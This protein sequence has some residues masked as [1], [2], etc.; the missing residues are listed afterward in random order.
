MTHDEE[1][2]IVDL[3]DLLSDT[4]FA[5]PVAD[6]EYDSFAIENAGSRQSLALNLVQPPP[7]EI[8][9]VRAPFDSFSAGPE[10]IGADQTT[11]SVVLRL[12]IKPQFALLSFIEYIRLSPVD[13]AAPDGRISAGTV[14]GTATDVELR[15]DFFCRIDGGSE[16]EIVPP[17]V[18]LR[19]LALFHDDYLNLLKG[20]IVADAPPGTVGD[21][22]FLQPQLI[23]AYDN[24]TELRRILLSA[25]LKQEA[26]LLN[27]LDLP[28]S[29]NLEER[30]NVPPID[31]IDRN[32]LRDS[33]E[34]L[35]AAD[36]DKFILRYIVG[37]NLY[38]ALFRADHY[39][40]DLIEL[41][42][43]IARNFSILA[44]VS[45]EQKLII[46]GPFFS[47]IT[48]DKSLA[49]IRAAKYG[50]GWLFQVQGFTKGH[51]KLRGGIL[52]DA[53]CPGIESRFYFYETGPGTF[54]FGAGFLP[55]DPLMT[56]GFDNASAI[57]MDGL[58]LTAD[59]E[60]IQF[61]GKAKTQGMPFFGWLEKNGIKYYVVTMRKDTTTLTDVARTATASFDEI[62]DY[63]LELGAIDVIW[64]DGDDSVGLIMDGT[65]HIE[66]GWKKK[67]SM[68]LAIGFRKWI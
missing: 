10:E 35:V 38:V 32:T 64:T 50:V 3:I 2:A 47:I 67:D 36:T 19:L 54:E 44:D 5:L 26:G 24:E 61:Q 46:N 52:A 59:S 53:N 63:L 30:L 13:P 7:P 21:Q 62:V 23:S 27:E 43:N 55:N 16:I 42:P 33:F 34:A 25:A 11:P 37:M 20:F 14:V 58:A 66:P 8:L 41:G 48:C 39:E 60:Y 17:A 22:Y 9:Q 57:V 6:S 29:S 40:V 45:P 51:L 68:P 15:M 56:V 18:A 65:L 28:I 49:P 1:A 31:T 4:D 12:D